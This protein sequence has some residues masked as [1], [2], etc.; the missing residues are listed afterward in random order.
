[1]FYGTSNVQLG[2]KLIKSNYP[3]LTVIFGVEQTVLSL[4]NNVIDC[5]D[6]MDDHESTIAK[7]H[8]F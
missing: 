1:M 6:T 5:G 2:G 4:F 3:K 7:K 8:Q